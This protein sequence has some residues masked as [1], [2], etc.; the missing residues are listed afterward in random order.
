MSSPSAASTAKRSETY[1]VR[2]EGRH[3]EPL[4]K[5]AL[6]GVQ[7]EVE[8]GRRRGVGLHEHGDRRRVVDLV[9][10]Q[11]DEGRLLAGVDVDRDLAAVTTHDAQQ[12]V[13][14]T[15]EAQD[16]VVGEDV[17]RL[18]SLLRVLPDELLP[19]VAARGRPP[20]PASGGTRGAPSL[21]TISRTSPSARGACA[22]WYSTPR[23]RGATTVGT[24][25]GSAVGTSQASHVSRSDVWMTM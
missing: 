12:R 24:A 23:R 4:A 11:A 21:V 1:A 22:T 8:P 15:A 13:A 3:V 20:A 14:V 18:E 9:A 2:L 5:G 17:R 7:I 6:A 25:V 10:V 19:V 16:D